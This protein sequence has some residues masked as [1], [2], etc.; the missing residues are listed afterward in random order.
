MSSWAAERRF[1]VSSALALGFSPSASKM[2]ATARLA[3]RAAGGPLTGK[4]PAARLAAGAALVI[5]ALPVV[6]AFA[7]RSAPAVLLLASM[8]IV[9]CVV[10][11][12]GWSGVASA[13]AQ[14]GRSPVGWASLSFVALSLVSWSWSVDRAETWRTLKEAVVPL[15]AGAMLLCL[16]PRMAPRWIGFAVAI[17]LIAAALVSIAELHSGM[18]IRRAL[19]LRVAAF[20]YNRPVLTLLALFW[21]LCALAASLPNASVS[22]LS[23]DDPAAPRGSAQVRTRPNEKL[24]SLALL[25]GLALAT[26]AIWTSQSGTAMFAQA[27]S[28]LAALVAWRFPRLALVAAGVAVTL[29]FISI[30]AFGDLAWRV[31]PASTYDLLAW[32][33]AADRVEIWRSFGAAALFHPILGTGLGTSVTLGD[34]TVAAEVASEFRRMLA[35]GHPHNGYL[36]IGVELG[37]GGCA[38]AILVVLTMLWSWRK[39][40]GPPL[41]SRVGLFTMV[42]AT[43]LVGHGAWQAWWLAI[44]FVAA[45]LTRVV[46]PSNSAPAID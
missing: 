39:L 33:H 16:L 5:A 38:L 8:V 9:A 34:T 2:T 28:I 4:P 3:G 12:T 20:E 14:V 1:L 7:N 35:V 46:S 40:S 17:G 30:Y 24:A 11:D 37:A 32:A 23:G 19:H 10:A 27:L 25:F 22:A 43:M 41:W 31:L 45:T 36:Q 44:I 15:V 13:F 18:P 21:P 26:L 29:V 42:A 6:M